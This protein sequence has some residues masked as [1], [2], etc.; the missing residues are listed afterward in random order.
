M[1]DEVREYIR[2]A[3]QAELR[4]DKPQAV[5]LLKKAATMVRSGG[6]YQRALQL[7][8]HAQRLDGNQPE[9][10]DEI[11]RLEWLPDKP[12]LRAVD[13][14]HETEEALAPLRALEESDRRMMDRGPTLSDPDLAAWCSSCC[15]VSSRSGR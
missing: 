12:F 4:G 14:E 11:R 8:R 6:N 3:Q 10:L 2:A 5:E 13:V 9:L 15:R 7:L 1:A